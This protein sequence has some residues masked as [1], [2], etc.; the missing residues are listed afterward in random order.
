MFQA[1]DHVVTGNLN[2]FSYSR[3]DKIVFKGPR[4]RLPS[5]IDFNRCREEIASTLNDF[6]NGWC[7]RESV[8]CNALQ[9][10]KL[11]TFNIVDKRICFFSQNANILPPKPKFLFEAGYPRIT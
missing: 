5:Y 7:R 3:V 8:K 11:S 2:I 9:K 6:S 1:A 10:R 4:Y